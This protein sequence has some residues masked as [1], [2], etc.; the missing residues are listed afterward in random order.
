MDRMIRGERNMW[1][2][3]QGQKKVYG[4]DVHVRFD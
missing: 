2:T 1:S 4:L 3:P